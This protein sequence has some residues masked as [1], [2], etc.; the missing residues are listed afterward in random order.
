[1][2]RLNVKQNDRV[3]VVSFIEKKELQSWLYSYAIGLLALEYKKT[4]TICKKLTDQIWE[5]NVGSAVKYQHITFAVA[6][7]SRAGNIML[8]GK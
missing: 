8:G 2:I 6:G 4:L 5:A 7:K 1:M 3:Q